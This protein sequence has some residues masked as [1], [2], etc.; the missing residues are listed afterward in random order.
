[1]RWASQVL[2][3]AFSVLLVGQAAANPIN[4]VPWRVVDLREG[5]TT[6]AHSDSSAT[7]LFFDH[8]F[9]PVP[10]APQI[11]FGASQNTTIDGPSGSLSGS[12]AAAIGY[13]VQSSDDVAASSFFDVFFDLAT[14][15][16]YS[17]SGTLQANDD[18]GFARARLGLTGP[19][20][21]SF[22][23][24]G[25]NPNVAMAASGVL[26]PGTYRL[27]VEAAM[28]NGGNAQPGAYMGGNAAF[29]FNLQLTDRSQQVAEPAMT[30]LLAAGLG[31]V[32]SRRRRHR[33]AQRQSVSVNAP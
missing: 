29:N 2:A 32:T 28:D 19:T 4:I 33:D 15:H 10:S 16:T 23:A 25:V 8:P 14:P 17:L 30:L 1:M 22:I 13:S 20:S 21:L 27:V 5:S 9:G 31:C 7:G 26:S 18:G 12:G 24:I 3:T 6:V 11:I